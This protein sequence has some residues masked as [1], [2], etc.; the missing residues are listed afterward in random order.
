MIQ[1]IAMRT[2]AHNRMR[3]GCAPCDAYRS[4]DNFLYS[5]KGAPSAR[6]AD[7][8]RPRLAKD[9]QD[10]YGGRER[11]GQCSAIAA[12]GGGDSR[13][14]WRGSL[15]HFLLRGSASSRAAARRADAPHP[16]A[17]RTPP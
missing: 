7:W 15:A 11:A 4:C 8:H 14:R 6:Q 1:G 2:D 12:R 17:A 5:F 13:R 16:A 9:T 3:T 10:V